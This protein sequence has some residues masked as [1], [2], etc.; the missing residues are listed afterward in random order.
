MRRE[1]V[2]GLRALGEMEEGRFQRFML[3]EPAWMPGGALATSVLVGKVGGAVRAYANVCRHHPLPLDH[4]APAEAG[5]MAAD[6]HHLECHQHGAL[7]RPTDGLCTDGPCRGERLFP[8]GVE[9]R[10]DGVAVFLDG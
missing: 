8:A 6:G 3:P 1:V 2:I 5:P 10:E 4:D 7:Y 9:E